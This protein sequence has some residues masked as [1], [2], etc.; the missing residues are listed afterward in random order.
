M[1]RSLRPTLADEIHIVGVPGVVATKFVAFVIAAIVAAVVVH[2]VTGETLAAAPV[3][4]RPFLAP[5]LVA[6]VIPASSRGRR[7][8]VGRALV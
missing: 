3:R 4:A 2:G 7:R 6:Y 8:A 5:V 1:G